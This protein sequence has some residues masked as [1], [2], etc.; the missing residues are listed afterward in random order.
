M[1]YFADMMQTK[2]AYKTFFIT[3]ELVD[4]FL[5][6]SIQD[7]DIP[8]DVK[9][10][11]H[12]CFLEDLTNKHFVLVLIYRLFPNVPTVIFISSHPSESTSALNDKFYNK[13][14]M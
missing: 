9:I 7:D 5:N 1:H 3:F 12:Y 8:R 6:G 14:L 11:F 10:K 2:F 4:A 13:L